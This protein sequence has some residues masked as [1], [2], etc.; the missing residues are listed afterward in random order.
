VNLNLYGNRLLLWCDDLEQKVGSIIVAQQHS[1]RSR[2][3]TVVAVG[4][5]VEN[6]RPGDKVLLS[7]YTGVHLH[8]LGKEL[9][10]QPVDE[11]RH[12]IVREDELLGKLT[13]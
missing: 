5:G 1:E 13:E 8:L 11:D 6:Y 3:A 4:D 12:R 10:G 9:F 2:T 7:W